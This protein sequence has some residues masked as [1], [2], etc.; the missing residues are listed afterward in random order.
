MISTSASNAD[1]GS[2]W[3]YLC[4]HNGDT[5]N[6]K[7]N[8]G[9]INIPLSNSYNYTTGDMSWVTNANTSSIQGLGTIGYL[10]SVIGQPTF[11]NTMF[12]GF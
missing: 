10:S 7:W 12:I 4:T 5:Y 9:S 8:A 1:V 6:L 2:N 3:I 11:F